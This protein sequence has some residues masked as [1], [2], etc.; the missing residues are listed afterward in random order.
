MFLFL[1]IIYLLLT[2]HAFSYLRFSFSPV[3]VAYV[4]ATLFFQLKV[5]DVFF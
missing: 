5:L 2:Q 3:H 4:L 1:P